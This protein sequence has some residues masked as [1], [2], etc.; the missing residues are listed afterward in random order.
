MSGFD[1]HLR[2][3][4]AAIRGLITRHVRKESHALLKNR[5]NELNDCSQHGCVLP[6]VAIFSNSDHFSEIKLKPFKS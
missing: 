5:L 2:W 4:C 1:Q 3:D 6:C